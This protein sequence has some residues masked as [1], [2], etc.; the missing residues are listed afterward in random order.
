MKNITLY[1]IKLNGNYPWPRLRRLKNFLDLTKRKKN[2]FVN[3]Y[4]CKHTF[5]CLMDITL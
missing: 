4:L 1:Q 5:P 2:Y 3:V